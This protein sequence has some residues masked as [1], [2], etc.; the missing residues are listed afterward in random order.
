MRRALLLALFALSPPLAAQ[1]TIP[2]ELP[3]SVPSA[4]IPATTRTLTVAANGNLQAALDS[5]KAG[6]AIELAR[7]GRYVGS[8]ILPVKLGTAGV[9]LRPAAGTA[10]PPAGTRITP[11][12]AASL[13]LP[14][15]LS[16]TQGYAIATALG[17]HHW[18]L[19]GLDIGVDSSITQSY[20]IVGLGDAG[21]QGQ[22]TLA[23]T[24][25]D[26]VLSQVYVH[27]RPELP[28]RRCIALNSGATAI[29][30]SW[31]S[32]CHDQGADAQAIAGWNGPGPYLVRNNELQASTEVVMFGGSDAL[33]AELSPAD[34]T[35]AR[36][37]LFKPI[38][39]KGG[40]WL[41]KCV[42][43]LKNAKRVL[44]EGNVLEGNW[45]Q[46][47]TGE[48]FTIKSVNQD[49]TAPWSGTT[50]LTVRL[51][52]VRHVGG[53][54]NIHSD[55]ER[56]K[57]VIPVQR[58]AITDNLLVGLNS[59]DYPGSGKAFYFG[60]HIADLRVEHNTVTWAGR[61]GNNDRA[62]E[63][64]GD[65]PE[66]FLRHR[67]ANN[68]FASV[69]GLGL[70][71]QALGYPGPVWAAWAP[72]GTLAGNV[73]AL[74]SGFATGQ[75][76]Q[77]VT[78]MPPGNRVLVSDDTTFTAIGFGSDW[79]LRSS[80]ALRGVG[81]DGKDPG[82][83]VRA[84]LAATAGVVEGVAPVQP[85]MPTITLAQLRAAVLAIDRVVSASGREN[86]VTKAALQPVAVYLHALL[87][88]TP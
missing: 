30:D 88:A 62:L 26:L 87:G 35:I 22:R 12:M 65:P 83:D 24:A 41:I 73:F 15:I 64:E 8:F 68:L 27:G 2:P 36:N 16:N 63:Y 9:V 74:G 58:V 18:Y 34:I 31:V 77:W 69:G 59:P 37:H 51:N 40:P 10:L 43:E 49:G 4:T 50:D 1:G 82:A 66:P 84:V 14:R 17:A 78:T 86:A 71:G 38:A 52:V 85:S 7:C 53:G 72:G 67:V 57:P 25:H 39:W 81:T 54:I 70:T 33:A 76:N 44:I 20:G 21:Q 56:T 5:A 60:G 3:R 75:W 11:A 47:W 29:V 28:L 13:C 23:Q 19:V 79:S 32:E 6:D 80:S 45:P 55:P 42:F 46:A 48:G 61:S